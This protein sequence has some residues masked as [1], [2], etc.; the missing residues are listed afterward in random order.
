[1]NGYSNYR[2]KE[3][4]RKYNIEDKDE[5]IFDLQ[6]IDHSFTGRID[7]N[8][9]NTF[10]LEAS[11][12]LVNS[13]AIFEMGY[14][15]AAY[16]CL[17]ESI[18]VATLMAY[19]VDLDETEKEQEYLKWKVPT[20]RFSMQKEMIRILNEKG[21]VI[22]DM[23]INMTNF[24]E[25]MNNISNELNKYVH[26]QGLNNLYLSKNHPLSLGNN[27]E[28]KDKKTIKNFEYYLKQCIG[29]VAIMR[30]S[31]DP[32]PI[33]LTNEEI[34]NRTNDIIMEP[35][36]EEFIN[37]YL[38]K[39]DIEAYKKTDFYKEHYDY[40]MKMPLKSSCVTDIIKS[41]YINLNQKNKILSEINLLS[42][43]FNIA[44]LLA[45]KI[46]DSTKIHT[47]GGFYTFFSSNMSNRNKW[48][49]NSRDFMKFK[50]N[51]FNK[52]YDEVFISTIKINDELFYI[53]HNNK[54]SAS[55]ISYIKELVIELNKMYD[56]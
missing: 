1:M 18:E 23:R 29:I 6:N 2:F 54:F 12:M 55:D 19:F 37:K 28:F 56:K 24:F 22:R 5:I 4:V 26:K 53:E 7:A 16:Y 15:D 10:I 8:I 48:G 40:I 47:Y 9:A 45:I 43:P 46:K 25:K 49:F 27:P 41:H 39:D 3:H 35:Y 38:T 50:N 32:F 31:I 14:F 17:R 13:I 44:A 42:F 36:S 34:Y 52:K 51:D 11:Q 20:N 21:E 33:L 30:L